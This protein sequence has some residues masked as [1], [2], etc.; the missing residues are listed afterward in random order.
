MHILA[1]KHR[2]L[3]A[4]AAEVVL[5]GYE[6][7]AK[8]YLLW[9]CHAL[10]LC[11]SWDVTFNESCFPF[12]Q[13]EEPHP[14]PMLPVPISAQAPLLLTSPAIAA[15]NT[16]AVPPTSTAPAAPNLP[17]VPRAHTPSPSSSMDSETRVESML[18]PD[19][20]E[21]ESNT[22]TERP[23]TPPPPPSPLT[24]LPTT[25]E[26]ASATPSS[27]LP[28]RSAG[29]IENRPPL[30][31][32]EGSADH[33]QHA[34]LLRE[35]DKAPC[36]SSRAP[37]PNPRYSG[38]NNAALRRGRRLGYAELLAAALVGRDPVT[39]AEA[40][41]SGEAGE[42][43]TA[44]QYEMDA[45][46]RNDMWDLVPLPPGC[47]V[48]KSKWVFKLKADRHYQACLV[49]KGFMQIPGVDFNE[50]FSPV[51]H[52][53]L[54]HLLLVLATLEDWHIHQM[55][56]KS[57]FLNGVLEEEIFMEQP[58][59]FVVAGQEARVCCL[60]KAIY[61]LKQASCTWNLQF[62]GV[63]TGLSFMQMFADAGMYVCNQH[64]G[65]GILIIILYVDD[66]TLLG[67]SLE[68]VKHM[69]GSLSDCYDMSDMGEIQ[70][71]LGIHIV[72]NWSDRCIE[73]DQTGYITSVLECFGMADA[74]PHNTL[75][76]S[77]ADVHLVKYTG[78]ASS[79]DTK[80]YQSL[81]GSLLYIQIGMRPDISF[82]V[83]HLAQYASN[84]SPQHLKLAQYVLGYLAGT[85]DMCIRYDSAT[86]EGLHGY[87]DSSLGDQT[88]DRHSTLGYVF[89]LADSVTSW[90]SCKQ[91]MVA[92]NTTEAEYM[93]MTD[94]ANQAAW[95]CSFLEELGYTIDNPIPLHGDNKGAIDLA[96]NPVTGRWSKHIEIKHH[97][98]REYVERSIVT[99]EH[100][101]TAEMLADGF[102]KLLAQLALQKQNR[103]MGLVQGMV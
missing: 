88:D 21:H 49:A 70:S 27:S 101:P 41:K 85:K 99:L 64:R 23:T 35:M 48:V 16:A 51:V 76:P 13:G 77:G 56:V 14:V 17:V 28:R 66:I 32:A 53:E 2:K 91:R 25:P 42:W 10:S 19:T 29:R 96:L 59:G 82:A 71:Y 73:I 46:A 80:H 61:G 54:L 84:P 83:S 89:L 47:K 100:T 75:L 39:F 5:V 72:C 24:S 94:A 37:V 34:D 103:D 95:Y 57:A 31:P 98:I 67:T 44:C 26:R 102:T 11:L 63:L 97:V 33:M 78:N 18:C 58:H 12:Q 40:M 43:T 62:H 90:S 9:D 79:S 30:P 60:K 50:T 6:Q 86:G 7:A 20:P 3:D 81:I 45:L 38:P 55:D 8:G 87:S 74:N 36:R 68:S 15:P 93:A 1:D 65:D 52:F 22:P 4:K 69:K 92:Q